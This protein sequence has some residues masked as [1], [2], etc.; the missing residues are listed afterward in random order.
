MTTKHKNEVIIAVKP[1]DLPL[2][3][4]IN[5]DSL[6]TQHPKVY[7]PIEKTGKER[8]PYCSTV[9]VLEKR[10]NPS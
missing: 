6:Y 9:Y 4:P 3:C 7:L 1:S 8:C 2:H 10:V 5:E